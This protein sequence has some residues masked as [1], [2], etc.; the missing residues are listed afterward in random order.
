MFYYI[1]LRADNKRTQI[2]EDTLIFMSGGKLYHEH[3]IDYT[4]RI[5]VWGGKLPPNEIIGTTPKEM[6]VLPFKWARQPSVLLGQID[7]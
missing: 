2:I 6:V 1:E 7:Y 3:T 5:A 4:K